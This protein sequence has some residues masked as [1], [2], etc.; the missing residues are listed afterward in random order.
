MLRLYVVV[1]FYVVVVM[2]APMPT[3]F[4]AL[5]R[6]LRKHYPTVQQFADA[7]GIAPSRLSRAMGSRGQSFDIA[8]CLKLAKVTG[9]SADFVLRA[10]GKFTVADLLQELYGTEPTR[11]TPEQQQLLSAFASIRTRQVQLSILA[12]VQ[13]VSTDEGNHNPI[14]SEPTA[15]A[16]GWTP[17]PASEAPQQQQQQRHHRPVR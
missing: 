9:S 16:V 14:I 15:T 2:S 7:L 8:G 3:S 6:R 5:L 11:L 10:A 17:A 1:V 4:A 13:A 12:I